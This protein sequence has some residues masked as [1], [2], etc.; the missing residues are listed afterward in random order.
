MRGHSYNIC[1]TNFAVLGKQFKKKTII[2]TPNDYLKI[3]EERKKFKLVKTQ[4]LLDLEKHIKKNS[5]IKISKMFRI[6][7]YPNGGVFFSKNYNLGQTE[8]NLLLSDLDQCFSTAGPLGHFCRSLGQTC[9]ACEQYAGPQ[10]SLMLIKI[11]I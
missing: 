11:V 5:I 6:D 7:Y 10:I 3:I 1:D 2:E 9:Q 8:T 4:V